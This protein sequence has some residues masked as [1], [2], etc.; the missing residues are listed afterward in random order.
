MTDDFIPFKRYV[1]AFNN[2][3]RI[4]YGMNAPD[5]NDAVIVTIDDV[6]HNTRTKVNVQNIS[7]HLSTEGDVY[8]L[9]PD[10]NG[11]FKEAPTWIL[12]DEAV[13]NA[14]IAVAAEMADV[15]SI[16]ELHLGRE[17]WSFISKNGVNLPPGWDF[18]NSVG[19]EI[20]LER[21]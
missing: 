1:G 6:W 12:E 17:Y 16:R 5:F 10:Q 18:V 15:L 4:Q 7:V 3:S 2:M 14:T 11:T 9:Y 13:Q 20:H 21:G 8:V 19:G